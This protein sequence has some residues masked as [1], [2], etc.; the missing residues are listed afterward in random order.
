MQS[1]VR[2]SIVKKLHQRSCLPR[3]CA[4]IGLAEHHK[5]KLHYWQSCLWRQ[6]AIVGLAEYLKKIHI[7]AGNVWFLV[8]QSMIKEFTK[9]SHCHWPYL[10]RQCVDFG[11]AEYDKK[12][13]IPAG[14]VCR[15]NV[16]L[17]VWQR[18]YPADIIFS[19]SRGQPCR[20]IWHS[21]N[22]QLL[23]SGGGIVTDGQSIVNG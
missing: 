3:Q 5:K 12:I 9:I 10:Q 17:L 7:A 1:L 20:G 2:R 22:I 11:P 14:H 6:C 21:R 16:S 19:P 13:Y 18:I 8:W 4:V 15:G 23:Q